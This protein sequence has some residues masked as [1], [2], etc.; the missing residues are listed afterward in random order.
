MSDLHF[1][2]TI[3]FNI[4][5]TASPAQ[6]VEALKD[7]ASVLEAQG[8]NVACGR[9]EIGRTAR[10]KSNP[11]AGMGEPVVGLAKFGL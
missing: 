4:S 10:V 8:C 9:S 11:R 1:Q 7:V 6:I 3:T 2:K 5:T